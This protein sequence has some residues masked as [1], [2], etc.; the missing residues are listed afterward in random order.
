MRR[1]AFGA[2]VVAGLVGGMLA[3]VPALGDPRED[4]R[5]PRGDSGLTVYEGRATPRQLDAAPATCATEPG[6]QCS[7][8]RHSTRGSGSPPR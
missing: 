8:A 1:A 2:M 7:T 6:P 3:A 5:L 4:R